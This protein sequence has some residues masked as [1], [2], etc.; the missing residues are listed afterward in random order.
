MIERTRYGRIEVRTTVTI[1]L[2]LIGV[3]TALISTYQAL[4]ND[5]LL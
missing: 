5:I 4:R 3:D 1:S 2:S